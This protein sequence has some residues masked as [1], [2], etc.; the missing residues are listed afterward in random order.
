MDTSRAA[1][2]DQIVEQ[3]EEMRQSTQWLLSGVSDED[4]ARTHDSLMGPVICDY[5]HRCQ[6]FCGFRCAG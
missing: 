1:P 3:L 4:L 2:R 6:L 5:P